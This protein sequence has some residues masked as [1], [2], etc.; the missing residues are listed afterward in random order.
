MPSC[1]VCLHTLNQVT[2][3]WWVVYISVMVGGGVVVAR[4][5]M[6]EPEALR[7]ISTICETA[8]H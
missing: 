3:R 4:W 5:I 1:A 8:A 7:H 2:T 6:D